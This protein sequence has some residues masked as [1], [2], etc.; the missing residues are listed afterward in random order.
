MYRGSFPIKTGVKYGLLITFLRSIPKFAVRFHALP[1]RVHTMAMSNADCLAGGRTPGTLWRP[2]TELGHRDERSQNATIAA[3]GIATNGARTLLGAFEPRCQSPLTPRG[4]K[5]PS[6]T[7]VRCP[8][9][10]AEAEAEARSQQLS[11]PEGQ[12]L[13]GLR[14]QPI[15]LMDIGAILHQHLAGERS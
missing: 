3:P 11:S 5:T 9:V 2:W 1:L 7:S 12:S 14:P 8:F 6:L 15:H 13:W 4:M 10:C